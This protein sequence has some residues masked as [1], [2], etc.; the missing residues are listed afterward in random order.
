M[1]LVAERVFASLLCILALLSITFATGNV[2]PYRVHFIDYLPS[3][4][5]YLFR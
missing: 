4:G 1:G 2:D 5:N 3:S